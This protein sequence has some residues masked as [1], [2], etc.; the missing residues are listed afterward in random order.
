MSQGWAVGRT[1]I[2]LMVMRQGLDAV[3]LDMTAPRRTGQPA[4]HQP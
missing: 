3:L 1:R 4:A 2:S